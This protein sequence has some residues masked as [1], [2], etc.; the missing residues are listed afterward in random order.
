[1]AELHLRVV[2]PQKTIIDRKVASVEFMGVDGSYGIKPNH[3][4]L[5]TATKPGIVTIHETDGN[6]E[7]MI[8]TDGFAEVR[9]NILSLVC[10]AGELA[11]EIDLERASAAEAKAREAIADRT[12][13]DIDLPR[14]EAALQRALLRQMLG[15]RKGGTGHV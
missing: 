13:I 15:R 12:K 3:A 14:A 6:V 9:R 4:A 5:M 11:S 10:E 7:E 2:T 1:M 8:V